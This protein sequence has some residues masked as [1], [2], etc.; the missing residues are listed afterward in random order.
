ME[1]KI[2][3]SST[4]KDMQ[5][6]RDLIRNEILPEIENHAMKYGITVNIVDLRWGINTDDCEDSDEASV[7]ILKTCFDEITLCKPFFIGIVGERYGWIP[8]IDSIKNSIDPSFSNKLN[9]EEK[10]VTEYEMDFAL[11]TYLAPTNTMGTL[12]NTIKILPKSENA[13]RFPNSKPAILHKIPK[14]ATAKATIRTPLI[15]PFS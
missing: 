8:S 7:K 14:A 12:K 4:F 6:E 1:C 9:F 5:N 3:I 2:F 13:Q 10:S 15:N 11:N